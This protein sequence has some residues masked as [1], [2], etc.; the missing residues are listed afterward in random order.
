MPAIDF[1]NS[2]TLNQEFTAGTTIYKWDGTA[3]RVKQPV[4]S[5][6]SFS[7]SNPAMN[8]TASAGTSSLASRSDHVHPSDTSRAAASDLSTH[9]SA[10]T[11]VHGI[12]NTAN[13]VYTDDSRLTDSRTPTA[14]ASTHGSAGSDAITIAQSQVTNLTTDLSAKAP[15]ASPALTGTPTSPTATAGTNTTQIATTAFV[16]TENASVSTNAQAGASYTLLLSDAGKLVEMS[17]G[18]A[19]TVTVPADGTTNFPIGT[20]IDILRTGGGE[21]SIAGATSPSTVTVNSEG[22]KLRINAQWQAV[23][24]IKRAANTWVLIGALKS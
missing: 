23:T 11:S 6:S 1:P 13:L 22:S 20:K 8:S 4:L 5:P 10:T 9:T 16:I 18:S 17:S 12:S 15:L 19:A 24:L 3:W 14:H 7:D 21:I 2:P